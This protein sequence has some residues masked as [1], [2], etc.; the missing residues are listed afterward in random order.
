[1]LTPA[2]Q[3]PRDP[4]AAPEVLSVS[5]VNA[6]AS[7]LLESA[8]SL[9]RV[10][11]EGE[12]SKWFVANSGH[13]YFTLKDDNAAVDCVLWRSAALRVPE[14]IRMGMSVVVQASA[15]LY[16]AQGRYQ[17]QADSVQPAGEGML[18]IRFQELRKKLESAGLFDPARKRAIPRTPRR[19]GV[20]T[21]RDSAAFQD[22]LH[23]LG[24]RAP[25]VEVVLHDARVQGAEAGPTLVRALGRL[26]KEDVDV[27]IV[28][29]GGGSLEDLWAFNEEAVV[30]AVA[31]CSHPVI[32]GVGH[33]TD[34]TLT[35]FAADLRAPTPSAAAEK[36]AWAVDELLQRLDDVE[37][38]AA[39]RL[40]G[41]LDLA[42]TRVNALAARPVLRKPG[43]ML[44]PLRN[45][46]E[47]LAARPVLRSA[48][49]VFAPVRAR[50][51]DAERRIPLAVGSRLERGQHAIARAAAG[52]DAL[53]PLKVL[54][55]GY[56]VATH[57]ERALTRATDVT[58][59]DVLRIRLAVGALDAEVRAVHS[60]S[61]PEETDA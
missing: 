35:D 9:Q 15:R 2:P 51:Q 61:P 56:A 16:Q 20:V 18:W 48:E 40:A 36:A 14:G 52:L 47:A 19:I 31:A 44:V 45:R 10:M 38:R 58:P 28:A 33:E 26:S 30:R 42:R 27:V 7:S 46:L 43:A 8:P 55:R 57:A 32:S 11:V 49:G 1:M 34:T 13:I 12:V 24:R 59:G 50:L 17:L 41:R 5:E 6:R 60:E 22:I 37:R 4:G 29:R 54:S 53:S 25:Y 3:G 39:K 23:V 21:S